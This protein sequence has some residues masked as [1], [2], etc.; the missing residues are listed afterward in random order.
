ML[1]FSRFADGK[2]EVQSKG[3]YQPAQCPRAKKSRSQV[4]VS[5]PPGREEEGQEMSEDRAICTPALI[6]ASVCA[7]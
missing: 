1:L 2:T 3:R 4:Q 5:W 6:F 7:C